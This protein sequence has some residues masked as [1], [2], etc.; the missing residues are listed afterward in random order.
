MI[1]GTSW[2]GWWLWPGRSTNRRWHY[3]RRKQPIESWA[4]S[5]SRV[6][7]DDTTFQTPVWETHKTPQ[8]K[9]KLTEIGSLPDDIFSE[10]LLPMVCDCVHNIAACVRIWYL[11]LFIA[12]ITLRR[13][14]IWNFAAW[15]LLSTPWH[16]KFKWVFKILSEFSNLKWVF[17]VNTTIFPKNIDFQWNLA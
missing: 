12:N 3:W 1:L 7:L 11:S 4:V 15:C 13:G 14:G 9:S 2:T 16:Q 6:L 8:N 5:Q 17:E 10:M